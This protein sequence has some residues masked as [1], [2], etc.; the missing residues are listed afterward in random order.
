MINYLWKICIDPFDR[1]S[2]IEVI[3]INVPISL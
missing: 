2:M 1:E 3:K